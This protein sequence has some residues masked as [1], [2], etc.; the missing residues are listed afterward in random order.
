MTRIAIGTDVGGTKT[1]VAVA[2]DGVE[3][4]R[5]EGAGGAVRPGRALASA[6]VITETVRRALATAG[7]LRGNILVVGA[8]GAGRQ[9]ERDELRS[10]LRAEDV[11]DQIHIT[12]DIEIAL[13]AAFGAGPGIVVTAGTGSVAVARDPFGRLHRAGGYG[14][15]MGDEG[16]G[17]AVS[18]AGLGAVSRAADG[19][20][21]KTVLTRL[22]L[23]ATRC[24]TLDQL[25]RWAAK[26]SPAEIAS[27]APA[28]LA[29]ASEGDTV[30][31]GILDYAARELAQLALQLLQHFGV[32]ERTQV[33]LATNGGL[34]KGES[35]VRRMLFQR[36]HE[37][38]RFRLIEAPV[39]PPAGALFIASEMAGA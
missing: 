32:D 30:A 3:V 28:I 39:D 10:A 37:E 4:A 9:E 13:A 2:V 22:L 7:R 23:E 27:L 31:Q 8:S 5:A 17:Y 14:W 16:S 20:S 33:G 29:G 25:I 26:A 12:G 19:R 38:P 21:P 6:A 1:A 11:A 15:Q 35:V 18:R 36:L 24:E 34:L